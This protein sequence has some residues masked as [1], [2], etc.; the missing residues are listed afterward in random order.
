MD[1]FVEL[2]NLLRAGGDD[3]PDTIYD[4]LLNVHNEGMS[5]PEECAGCAE[6]EQIIQDLKAMN[7]DLLIAGSKESGAG[8]KKVEEGE[9][10][11]EEG[12]EEEE[13]SDD[14]ES[15]MDKLFTTEGDKKNEKEDD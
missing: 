11:E 13:A 10:E 1:R 3:L 7:Y 14:P 6:R 12:E 4:D 8:E 15:K 9:K 5:A 2:L